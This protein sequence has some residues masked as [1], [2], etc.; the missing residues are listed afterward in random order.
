MESNFAGSSNYF[1]EGLT[2]VAEF[3]DEK[4]GSGLRRQRSRV[5]LAGRGEIV[6]DWPFSRQFSPLPAPLGRRLVNVA[7]RA[8]AFLRWRFDILSYALFAQT[9]CAAAMP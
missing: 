6:A 4:E 1:H 2:M 3:P 7:M 8:D 5:A 9:R